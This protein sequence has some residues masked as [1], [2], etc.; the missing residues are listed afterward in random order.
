MTEHALYIA[1]KQHDIR[2]PISKLT[3]IYPRN[4]LVLI[5]EMWEADPSLVS[6]NK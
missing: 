1:V 2:P 5:M 3:N 6:R 4:L